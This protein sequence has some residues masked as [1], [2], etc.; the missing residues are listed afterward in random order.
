LICLGGDIVSTFDTPDKVRL[1]KCALIEEVMIGE[2]K[3]I[4][5]SG[6]FI[7]LIFF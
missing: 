4:K 5:F 1:G 3:L 2:D 6:L 7:N